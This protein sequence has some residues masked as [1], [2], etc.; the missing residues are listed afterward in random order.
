MERETR[1]LAQRWHDDGRAAVVVEVSETQG[2]APRER[3]TRML[4][5][6]DEAHGT[7]GGGH[8]ELKAVQ[9]A[10]EMLR[11][12]E[13]A[14]RSEHYALGPSLGQCCGGAVDLRYERLDAASLQRWPLAPPLFRL[15]LYGAGHVGRAIAR[16]LATL[17]V[18]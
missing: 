7:I 18:E 13:L 15:Q 2:S 12:R 9:A 10:R 8:L 16:L 11:T 6:V 14:P 4:V 3:G 17:D 1:V 5:G